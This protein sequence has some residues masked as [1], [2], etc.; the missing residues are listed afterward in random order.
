MA[1]GP[2]ALEDLPGVGAGEVGGPELVAV[3]QGGLELAAAA[4]E[5][6]AQG[7]ALLGGQ[8]VGGEEGLGLGPQLLQLL[9]L[10]HI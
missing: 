10:I 1:G 5:P 6:V 9:S 2:R 8:A 4:L 7:A 3:A